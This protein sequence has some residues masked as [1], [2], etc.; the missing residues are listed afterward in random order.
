VSAFSKLVA[1]YNGERLIGARKPHY[2]RITDNTPILDLVDW[3][4]S[5]WK[6]KPKLAVGDA[7]YGTTPNI[8]GFEKRVP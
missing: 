3:I 8:V 5:R 6:I 7:R 4:C 2:Q 1:K